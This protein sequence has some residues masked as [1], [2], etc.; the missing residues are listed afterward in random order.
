MNKAKVTV[1]FGEHFGGDGKGYFR[2][3]AGIPK[4]LLKEVLNRIESAL[5]EAG[6][7]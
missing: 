1:Y 7:L 5:M 3:N 4:S 6:A 2:L